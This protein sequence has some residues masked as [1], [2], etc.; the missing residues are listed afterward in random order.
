M[1]GIIYIVHA[2]FVSSYDGDASYP[3]FYYIF[4]GC[5]VGQP[6]CQHAEQK[7]TLHHAASK[8]AADPMWNLFCFHADRF[9]AQF[10]I[11]FLLSLGFEKQYSLFRLFLRVHFLCQA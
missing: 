6:S 9:F 3:G 8:K 7:K 2:F 5:R 1:D 4:Y 10:P 11:G